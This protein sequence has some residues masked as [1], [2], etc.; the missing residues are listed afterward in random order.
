[1]AFLLL[2][3]EG[4]AVAV[5]FAA[6]VTACVARWS[7]RWLQVVVVV[8]AMFWPVAFGAV[9]TWGMGLLWFHRQ[10][11]LPTNWFA[12]FL[13]W[14]LVLVG[15]ACVVIVRGLRRTGAEAVPAGRAWPRGSLALGLGLAVILMGITVSNMDLAVKAQLGTVRAK[16]GALALAATP[17]VTDRDNAAFV[18][19]QA[20]AALT[21]LTKLPPPWQAKTDVWFG[22]EA[23][24]IDFKDGDLKAFLASQQHALA[25]LRKAGAMPGCH[26]EHYPTPPPMETILAELSELR[27]YC[28]LLALDAVYRAANGDSG[29]AV[30]DLAALYGLAGH[31]RG[32]PMLIGFL[33]GAA[34]EA[35]AVQTFQDV[36]A[37]VKPRPEELAR[38]TLEEGLPYRRAFQRSLVMEEAFGLAA[39]AMTGDG[40]GAA[41]SHASGGDESDVDAAGPFWRIFLL[42]DDLA[43]YRQL[44]R[45]FQTRAG[46]PYYE[47]HARGRAN[48]EASKIRPAGI[49]TRLLVPALV[50]VEEAAVRAD[51]HRQ[52]ARLAVA[53]VAY[54]AKNGKYPE[55][56]DALVPEYLPQIPTD[57]FDGQPLRMRHAGDTLVLYS[58][59]IDLT[60]D[61]GRPMDWTTRKGDLVVTLR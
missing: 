53:A 58:V 22:H 13:S 35:V 5:L 25:L 42:G 9:L 29:L 61:G 38:L 28:N 33:T 49:L 3:L 8:L 24:K 54:R 26:F 1:V 14:T 11:S 41:L 30:D 52:L 16:A 6:L 12:Y 31:T 57:P 39:F 36:L 47:T 23:D 4:L 18:Y 46:R 34:L 55:R 27:R 40:F 17:R 45:E 43:S 59:S 44:M 19:E 51:A 50:K 60:D 15:V 7:R 32:E 10:F 37:R 56:L 2:W 21:P 20:S 48:D